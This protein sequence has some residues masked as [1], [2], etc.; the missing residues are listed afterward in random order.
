MSRIQYLFN[1][2]L[3]SLLYRDLETS[4]GIEMDP[5]L[6]QP[7]QDFLDLV[8]HNRV[9]CLSQI[10]YETGYSL[11]TI[12]KAR[13]LLVERGLIEPMPGYDKD[14]VDQEHMAYRLAI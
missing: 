2:T 10:K 8:L 6:F 3:R 11:E 7:A 1:R 4:Q 5:N 14:Y 12:R 9:Q 13:D